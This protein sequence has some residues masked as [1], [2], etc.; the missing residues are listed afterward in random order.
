MG[1][2]GGSVNKVSDLTLDLSSSL[3]LG[4]MSLSTALGSKLHVE[5]T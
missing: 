3:D 4:V 1:Y 5:P 2:L